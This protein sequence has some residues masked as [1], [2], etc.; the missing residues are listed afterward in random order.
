[1]C[2]VLK[3]ALTLPPFFV[4]NFLLLL[5]LT[6]VLHFFSSRGECGDFDLIV[7]SCYEIVASPELF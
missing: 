2:S 4:P 3:F 5:V 6:L 7:I 1:M